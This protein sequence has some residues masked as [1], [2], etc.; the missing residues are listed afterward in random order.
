MRIRT[1]L[2]VTFSLIASAIFVAFG[3]TVYLLSSNYR[4]QDFQE[5]LQKR[6]VITEKVFLEKE[7]FSAAELVKIKNEFLHTLPEETEEVLLI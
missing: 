7:S 3:V 4:K 6:I 1:R 2:S 5:R